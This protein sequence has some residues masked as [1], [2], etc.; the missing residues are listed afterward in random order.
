MGQLDDS[1][2]LDWGPSLCLQSAD[3]GEG[4]FA[5]LGWAFPYIWE[6]LVTVWLRMALAGMNGC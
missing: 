6:W 3:L 5:D 1:F 4:G 2:S